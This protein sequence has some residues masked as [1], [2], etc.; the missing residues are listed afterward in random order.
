MIELLNIPEEFY[1]KRKNPQN[2]I[3]RIFSGDDSDIRPYI[4]RL[5]WVA[6]IKPGV[7]NIA[8]ARTETTRYDEIEVIS[9]EIT[10]TQE[11]YHICVPVCGAIRYPCL[12]VVQLRDRFLLG[13][14][15]FNAGKLDYDKN[16]LRSMV[17]SHWIFPDL[18]SSGAKKLL[19]DIS[20]QIVAKGDAESIYIAMKQC[21][22]N[23][24]LSGLTKNHVIALSKDLAGMNC[25]KLFASCIP[26]KKY[27]PVAAG[28]RGKYTARSSQ[29][30]YRYDTED[31]WHAYMSDER[32]RTI[33]EKRRY[34]DMS[35]LIYSIDS[36]YEALRDE[37]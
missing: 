32:I 5:E 9:L 24:A 27:S 23:F 26:Y 4:T 20:A 29:Y 34:R 36:K 25:E 2:L 6:S 35:D 13:V 22:Q 3:E 12:L 33:I 15:P 8:P 30:I 18:L 21:I 37:R 7:A 11:L 19:S 31:L 14:C 28:A 16:I 1:L 17:F 10:D